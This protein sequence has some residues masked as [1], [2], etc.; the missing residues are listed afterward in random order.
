MTPGRTYDS[1]GNL[2]DT[3]AIPDD[4]AT[5]NADLIRA[6]ALIAINGNLTFLAING[7]TAGQLAAQVTALTK[8]VNALIRLALGA[9]D[10]QAGT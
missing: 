9:T 7:P 6:R 2:L 8:Q 4:P 10:T 5:L 1:N 3:F